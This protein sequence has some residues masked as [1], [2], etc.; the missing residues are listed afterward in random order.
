MKRSTK[1]A[2]T[3]LVPTMTAFGC[4]QPTQ[5]IYPQPHQ[6]A[7]DCDVPAKP[8]EPPKPKCSPVTTSHNM[9]YGSSRG[10]WFGPIFGGSHSSSVSS[11]ASSGSS[12]VSHG[13]FGS[14]GF[15][16]SSGG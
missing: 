11:H 1:V 13:G 14:S 15:H 2:L 8:G 3:L 6:A 4:G 7:Q 9:H 5:T 12:H 16:F 10:S